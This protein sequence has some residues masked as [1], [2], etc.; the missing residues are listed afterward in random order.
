MRS[1]PLRLALAAALLCL[2]LS[3]QAPPGRA[4][5]E[6]V[7]TDRAVCAMQ[8]LDTNGKIGQMLMVAVPGTALSPTV[9]AALR[10]W[11]AGGVI[12]FADNVA[13]AGQL[14]SFIAGMQHAQ[15]LPLLVS[16]DQEGGE[17]V[18]I[19]VGL[20]PLPAEAYYGS[21]GSAARVY[22]DARAEGLGLKGLGV[23]MNL[24]PVVDVLDFP[25]SAIGTRSFG[26]NP[27]VDAQLVD[28]A[29]RGYQSAGIAATAK[30]FLALGSVAANADYSLPVVTADRA[31]LEG[32]DMVPMRAAVRAGVD[33]L[34]VTRVLIQA[35]DPGTA[36]YASSKV[37]QGII[38]GELGY[39]GVITTDS[40]LSGA[41][42]AGPGPVTAALAATRAG[43]DILLFGSGASLNA[44]LLDGVVAA[45]R[46]AVA[47]GTV[48]MSR[49]NDA[50]LH[51][52]ELKKHLGLLPPC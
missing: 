25:Q 11:K 16:T 47:Q 17:V 36:A 2:T 48:S 26:P 45:L 5:T 37:V 12:L 52:L 50:A 14:R 22:A 21:L 31:T 39:K 38:R 43:D 46:Q 1:L 10:R 6:R 30:H 7:T 27:T 23:N 29:V 3:R 28:A 19:T 33:A 49:L 13:S 41:V 15:P 44:P 32:R 9:T 18:R 4:A 40:L 51:V 8:H 34:M 35:F 20:N 42:L 24:A